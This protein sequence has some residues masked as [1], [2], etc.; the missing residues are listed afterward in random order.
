MEKEVAPF[1][2]KV[3]PIDPKTGRV[4][5]ENAYIMHAQKSKGRIYQRGSEF[6]YENGLKVPASEN[7]VPGANVTVS[8]EKPVVKAA[9]KETKVNTETK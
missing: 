7:W 1:D 4:I 8:E 3:H 9:A 2:F 5:G 6:F